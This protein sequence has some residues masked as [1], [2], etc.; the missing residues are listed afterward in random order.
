MNLINLP[1]HVLLKIVSF[2]DPCTVYINFAATAKKIFLLMFTEKIVPF[3]MITHLVGFPLSQEIFLKN[4]YKS[5]FD[6]LQRL[7]DPLLENEELPFYAFKGDCGCDENKPMY[8]FN[9]IFKK[10]PFQSVCTKEGRNFFI[11]GALACDYF[12]PAEISTTKIASFDQEEINEISEYLLHKTEDIRQILQES[13]MKRYEYELQYRP[14]N[15]LSVIKDRKS[16][17]LN[18]SH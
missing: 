2:L 3:Q 12:H 9:Y 4:D 17:R 10:A 16:T 8:F 14:L 7:L 6:F 13:S 11:S 1:K 15:R 5:F 18:S